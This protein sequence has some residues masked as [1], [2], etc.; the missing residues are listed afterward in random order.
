MGQFSC[1]LPLL[2]VLHCL[3]WFS[4]SGVAPQEAGGGGGAL[5]PRNALA[6]LYIPATLVSKKTVWIGSRRQVL[7][8]VGDGVFPPTTL[9]LSRLL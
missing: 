8:Q 2:D 9:Y 4:T 7:Y 5:S 3:V 1:S 6:R